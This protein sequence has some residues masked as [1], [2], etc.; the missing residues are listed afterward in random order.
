MEF[1]KKNL[2]CFWTNEQRAKESEY[3]YKS[4]GEQ[5]NREYDAKRNLVQKQST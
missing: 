1:V 5:Q 4:W 2:N 3:R